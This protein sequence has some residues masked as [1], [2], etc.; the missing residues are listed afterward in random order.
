MLQSWDFAGDPGR[1]GSNT[2]TVNPMSLDH[3][4]PL[5]LGHLLSL[6]GLD[7]SDVLVLRHTFKNAVLEIDAASDEEVLDYT[8]AQSHGNK[9]GSR[10]PRIWLVFV[11]DGARRSRFHASYENHGEMDAERTD[12]HRFFDLRPSTTLASMQKR[13]VIEWSKDPVNWA[14][15]GASAAKLPVLEIA[16]RD[17]VPF[18]GFDNL[19]IGHDLLK[20]VVNEQEGRYRDW[21]VALRSVKGVY[22]ISDASS[23]RLYVGRA[24]GTDTLLQRWTAYAQTGHGGNVELKRLIQGDPAHP[25]HF[26]FSILRV[27]SPAATPQEVA[28][29]ESYYKQAMLTQLF[30]LNRN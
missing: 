7:A 6:S 14:K 27:F 5:T 10:P 8:R 9:V 18:P 16:D 1:S 11:A 29:A 28:R 21:R 25:R 2:D 15:Q 19:L 20:S 22:L 12:T 30:G 13:L 4:I 23:G 24:D 17:K 26:V 3:D